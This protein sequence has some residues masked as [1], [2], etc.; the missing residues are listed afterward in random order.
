MFGV[1]AN[2]NVGSAPEPFDEARRSAAQATFEALSAEGYRTL[3]VAVAA[4]SP[5]DAYT[6]EAERRMT[7]VGFA[8]F[9]DPPKA[10]I[11]PVLEALKQNGIAVVIM[12]GDN[13]FVTRKIATDV[14][15]P[16]DRLVTG[17]MVDA[18]E[19]A[20]WRFRQSRARCSHASH[21]SR[22]TA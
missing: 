15:L 4:V 1:C 22:R 16:T 20:A 18:M 12:T 8:A 11:R 17:P 9:L 7:L 13:Q 3:G 6:T 14:G 5:A 21:P 19:D 2:V 10:G